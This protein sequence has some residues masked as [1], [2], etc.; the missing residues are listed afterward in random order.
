M[1]VEMGL[2]T[3]IDVPVCSLGLWHFYICKAYTGKIG[4]ISVQ[5][6]AYYY[7][8]SLYIFMAYC[9]WMRLIT[10]DIGMLGPGLITKLFT[11]ITILIKVLFI[12]NHSPML[13]IKE[14]A[15]FQI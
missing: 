9:V 15:V 6:C 13:L 1:Y 4:L 7:S 10:T 5:I 12:R 11:D 14:C 8:R 3:D 2:I